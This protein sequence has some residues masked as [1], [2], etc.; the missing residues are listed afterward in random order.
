MKKTTTE[1]II[2]DVNKR[3][4]IG[5]KAKKLRK[6]G[7]ILANIFGENF[8]SQSIS[9]NFKDFIRVFKTVKE[10]GIVYLRLDKEEIPCLVKNIQ[11]HPVNN[12][13]LHVDFR[14]ID[15]KKK[16]ETEVPVK[17]INQ[18]EAVTQKGGVLLVQTENLLIEA[19]PE[20]IPQHIEVD[21]SFIKEIGQEIKVSDLSISDKYQIKS[22]PDKVIVS[23]I[24]HKEE[25][26]TPETTTAQPEV[27]SEKPEGEG[28]EEQSQQTKSE[29]TKEVKSEQ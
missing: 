22:S 1:K 17:I 18:S 4:L 2:L 3:E 20:D 15:L 19:L 8:N 7:L 6:Q 23:V 26:V 29:E 11:Y 9:V 28:A 25:S 16:I 21:I 14:K 13:I 24:A 5:K 27:I 12:N 10:T